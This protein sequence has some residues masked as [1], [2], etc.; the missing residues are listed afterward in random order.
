MDA[1]ELRRMALAASGGTVLDDDAPV[2]AKTYAR[3]L[4]GAAGSDEAVEAVLSDL[5]EFLED[6]FLAHPEFSGLLASPLVS[7][8]ERDRVLDAILAGRAHPILVNFLHVLNRKGRLDLLGE[9]AIQA[10]AIQD[11]RSN[12]QDVFVKTAVALDDGQLA[13]LRDRLR[14]LLGFEPMLQ[15]SVD[16]SLI[17][18]LVFQTGDRVY[19][20]SLRTQLE[21]LRT[22]ILE[23]KAL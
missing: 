19:D 23:R 13:A 11:R 4:I 16:P 14:G 2:L 3:A 12:R 6:V 15:V 22:R 7:E 20:V 18:G 8:E 10:K 1:A 9:V 21:R 5:H 17:G